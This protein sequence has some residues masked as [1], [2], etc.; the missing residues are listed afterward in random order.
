MI[1]G[2][3]MTTIHTNLDR[4]RVQV[5]KGQADK[6]LLNSDGTVTDCTGVV[7][8]W[9]H[10][11]IQTLTSCVYDSTLPII[12][13]I[14]TDTV[15]QLIACLNA[16]RHQLRTVSL[17]EFSQRAK[18]LGFVSEFIIAHQDE[19]SRSQSLRD[20]IVDSLS[21][22]IPPGKKVSFPNTIN[23]IS[24][25]VMGQIDI[26]L[27]WKLQELSPPT[28]TNELLKEPVNRKDIIDLPPMDD[29]IFYLPSIYHEIFSQIEN[30]ENKLWPWIAN[31]WPW[32]NV[33]C[34]KRALGKMVKELQ[35]NR[36]KSP[37][38]LTGAFL[39]QVIT[40]CRQPNIPLSKKRSALD[41][42][43]VAAGWC[44]PRQTTESERQFRKLTEIEITMKDKLLVWKEKFIEGVILNDFL[45]KSL[46][47][48]DYRHNVHYLNAIYH[49]WGEHLGQVSLQ[50][51]DQD[52]YRIRRLSFTWPELHQ[53]LQQA[54]NAQVAESICTQVAID[55][56]EGEVREFLIEVVRTTLPSIPNAEDFVTEEYFTDMGA[57]NGRGANRFLRALS[58]SFPALQ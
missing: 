5:P 51:P 23:Q 20:T 45:R 35:Q 56:G 50:A 58:T 41:E 12:V 25:D 54:W 15:E 14:F 55:N 3:I 28:L 34:A 42:L 32:S 57:L 38:R 21:R 6:F 37:Y 52:N 27:A 40:L 44:P 29:S 46:D 31:L 24:E 10:R 33:S 48:N 8:G 26:V 36:N 17:E 9:M 22:L 49:E 16:Q 53:F 13:A 1:I 18:R 11:T 7:T 47:D 30:P 19:F 43:V 2:G 4:S 39:R